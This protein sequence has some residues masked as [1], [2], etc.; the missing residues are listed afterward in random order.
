[1][2]TRRY[3]RSRMEAFPRTPEYASWLQHHR[4]PGL[5]VRLLSSPYSYMAAGC[6]LFVF[7]ATGGAK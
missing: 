5:F 3:P 2:N 4:G 6:C 7:L 1:M